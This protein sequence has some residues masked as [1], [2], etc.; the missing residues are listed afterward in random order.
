MNDEMVNFVFA[1]FCAAVVV[2]VSGFAFAFIAW[3]LWFK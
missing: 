2:S 3:E 1:C